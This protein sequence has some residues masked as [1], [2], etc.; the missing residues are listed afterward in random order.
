MR[1]RWM[2]SPA[3]MTTVAPT[4]ISAMVIADM[5]PPYCL[6]YL[7]GKIRQIAG[8]CANSMNHKGHEGTQRK[9]EIIEFPCPPL[10]AGDTRSKYRQPALDET[11]TNRRSGR[12]PF[13]LFLRVSVPPWC[14][15]FA[16]GCLT[17]QACDHIP[18]LHGK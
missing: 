1:A 8:S 10:S 9:F 18:M 7:S 13:I 2:T 5:G 12:N 16:F 3:R 6:C 14:K 15:G 11:A 4:I 17:V